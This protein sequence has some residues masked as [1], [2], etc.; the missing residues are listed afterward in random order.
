MLNNANFKVIGRAYIAWVMDCFGAKSYSELTVRP[1]FV[2]NA[3]FPNGHEIKIRI[4]A[5]ATGTRYNSE[6]KS[7]L[8][9]MGVGLNGQ[10]AGEY[11]EDAWVA[12]MHKFPVEDI[13]W[14]LSFMPTTIDAWSIWVLEQDLQKLVSVADLDFCISKFNRLYPEL[15]ELLG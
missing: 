8:S 6:R 9:R 12:H 10:K 2:K 4:F 13:V 5:S 14:V 15:T 1:W 7:H 11:A 3:A